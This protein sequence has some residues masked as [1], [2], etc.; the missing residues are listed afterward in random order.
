MIRLQIH[1]SVRSELLFGPVIVAWL[2]VTLS[3]ADWSGVCYR[4]GADDVRQTLLG[5]ESV[6]DSLGKP[7]TV[8]AMVGMINAMNHSD[9]LDG[10]DA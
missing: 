10:L 2:I 6:P 9:G 4:L 5:L 3:G 8:F 7:F 1:D